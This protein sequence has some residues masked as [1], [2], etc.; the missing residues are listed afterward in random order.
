MRIHEARSRVALS[1]ATPPLL[2]GLAWTSW[3]TQGPTAL[4]ASF[5]LLAAGLGYVVLF[6]FPLAVE[7]DGNGI[8]RL[9]LLRRRHLPWEEV[10]RIVK[11]RRRGLFVVD[12]AGKRHILVD[13]T[14]EEGELRLLRS[15]AERHQVSTSF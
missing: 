10:V 5:A 15:Q 8:H 12:R 7:V 13:R 14:L 1:L 6:D 3:L 11:P 9:S 4:T 2:F